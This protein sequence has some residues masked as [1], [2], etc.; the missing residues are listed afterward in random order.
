MAD[1]TQVADVALNW[2][3][4]LV[5]GPDQPAVARGS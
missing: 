5:V 3:I 1:M 4:S 2:C